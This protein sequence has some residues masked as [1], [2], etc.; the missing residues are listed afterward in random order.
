[1]KYIV[2]NCAVTRYTGGVRALHKNGD[3]DHE[4]MIKVKVAA[5]EERGDM[6]GGESSKD[7]QSENP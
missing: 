1:M 5:E 6:R 4:T 7:L 3:E 2:S